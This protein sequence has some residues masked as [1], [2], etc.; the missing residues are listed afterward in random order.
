MAFNLNKV[1]VGGNLTRDVD[2]RTIPNGTAVASGS[3][4]SNHVYFDK[5]G[6]KQQQVEYINFVIWGKRAQALAQYLTKGTSIYLEGRLQTRSW[7]D[8]AHPDKKNYKTEVIVSEIQF[9][10]SRNSGGSFNQDAAPSAKPAYEE[11]IPTV[12]SDEIINDEDSPFED[13]DDDIPL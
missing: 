9:A 12:D 6:Q 10:G 4:A 13:L 1:M 2:L 7:A 8:Q 5:A 11:S 3:L